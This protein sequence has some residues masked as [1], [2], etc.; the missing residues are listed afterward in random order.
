MKRRHAAWLALLAAVTVAA[1]GCSGSGS[2]SSSNN[3]QSSATAT[4]KS[5]GTVSYA[6]P[7][8]TSSMDPA[9]CGALVGFAYCSPVFSTLMRYDPNAKSYVPE[10]A[11]ALDST[12]GQNWTLH[13]RPDV[14]FSDGTPLNAD[15]VIFN[16]DRIKNPAIA[17]P[18][19]RTVQNITWTKVDDLTVSIKTASTNYRFPSLLVTQ[20]GCI[21]SP[22]AI[23]SAGKN[24]DSQ[25][26]GA[27]AF[28]LKKWTRGT[29]MEFEANPTYWQKGRPYVHGLVIEF[30]PAER[31]R[32][33]QLQTGQLDVDYSVS[34]DELSKA[35]ALSGVSIA[36]VPIEGGGSLA[37][38]FKDPVV[39][40]KGLRQAI[41]HAVN[42]DQVTQVA[43]PNSPGPDALLKPGN[44]ARDDSAK[45]PALDLK[46]AQQMFNDYLSR[47]GK[48]SETITITCFSS[49]PVQKTAA[50]AMQQQISQIKGLTVKLNPVDSPTLVTAQAKGNFQIIQGNATLDTLDRMYDLFHTGGAL[51]FYGYSDPIVDKA[52]DDSRATRDPQAALND[53]KTA[54]GEISTNGPLRF[55]RWVASNVLYQNYVH[56]I[57][58]VPTTALMGVYWENVWLSK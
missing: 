41:M 28:V 55:Y 8:Q 27:G 38:N 21:G 54:A 47:T 12:D 2:K 11:Q 50:E 23:K 40:D 5:G 36:P 20:L 33:D 52:M 1:S 19:A 48:S 16:W 4:P 58:A 14:K 6:V 18:A 46:Q 10:L 22:T 25:P 42:V 45:F 24:V 35:K 29:Q 31:Q 3:G 34:W 32:F 7:Y 30:V 57:V 51:N 49:V 44:P 26:V 15:A 13:L 37:F 56:G 9:L 17:S 39:K 43:F 53:Y